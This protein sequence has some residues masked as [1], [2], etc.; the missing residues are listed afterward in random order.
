MAENI[1]EVKVAICSDTLKEQEDTNYTYKQSSILTAIQVLAA[2]ITMLIGVKSK[3]STSVIILLMW[4]IILGILVLN[5]FV[6]SKI[7][8]QRDSLKLTTGKLIIDKEGNLN[9]GNI[10]LD[11]NDKLKFNLN[12][13]VGLGRIR[14]MFN[15]EFRI[16]NK[17]MQVR[18]NDDTTDTKMI[19]YFKDETLRKEIECIYKNSPYIH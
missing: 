13:F 17:N 5:R 8:V 18:V 10:E 12:K 1:Y 11:S 2:I 15:G 6:V 16:S 7:V 3:Y 14:T 19:M 9:I 4:I